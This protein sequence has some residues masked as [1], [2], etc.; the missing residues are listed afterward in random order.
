MPIRREFVDW[1]K[2]ALPAVIDRLQADYAIAGFCDLSNVIAVFPGSRAARRFLELLAEKTSGR[3]IPPEV[4][5]VGALPERLYQPKRPFANTLT[6]EFAWVEA[7][8]QI[9]RDRLSLVLS[10]IPPTKTSTPGS[11]SGE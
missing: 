2:P 3:N 4:V 5:T 8:Q 1:T 9:P 11:P 6:Q 10:Q 7:L